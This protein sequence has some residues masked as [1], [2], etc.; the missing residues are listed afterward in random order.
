MD[1]FSHGLWAAA[2]AKALNKK[3]PERFHV[4]KSF[5]WGVFPDFFAFA[6]PTGLILF[7]IIF[8]NSSISDFPRPHLTEPPSPDKYPLFA[9]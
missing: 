5:L 9:L 7:Q 8:G 1:I 2:G 6:I 3:Q 4:V